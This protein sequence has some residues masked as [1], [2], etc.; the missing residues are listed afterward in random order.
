[1]A[2]RC[3]S[4]VSCAASPAAGEIPREEWEGGTV[5]LFSDDGF[6]GRLCGSFTVVPG[7]A[8]LSWM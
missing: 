2:E 4:C 1:M 6:E 5:T 8:V 7:A 3:S